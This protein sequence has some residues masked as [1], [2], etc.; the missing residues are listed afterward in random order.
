MYDEIIETR[1][2]R[3]R[4]K[5]GALIGRDEV[6]RVTT[7]AP[8][9]KNRVGQVLHRMGEREPSHHSEL[10]SSGKLGLLRNPLL[11]ET[12]LLRRPLLRGEGKGDGDPLP[13]VSSG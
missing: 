12:A 3:T 10:E 8:L 9:S 2:L 11:R 4:G 5:I 7:A 13:E 1:E 6:E